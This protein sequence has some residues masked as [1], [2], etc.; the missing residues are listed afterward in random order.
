MSV[1]GVVLSFVEVSVFASPP[2]SDPC[3][4]QVIFLKREVFPV[5]ERGACSLKGVKGAAL[6]CGNDALCMCMIEFNF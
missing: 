1:I 2:T 5:L 3:A 6:R 4:W